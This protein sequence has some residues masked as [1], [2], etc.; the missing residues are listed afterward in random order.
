MSRSR[1]ATPSEIHAAAEPLSYTALLRDGTV[2]DVSL[3]AE[4]GNLAVPAGFANQR[5][6]TSPH[7]ARATVSTQSRPKL[8]SRRGDFLR[9]RVLLLTCDTAIAALGAATAIVVHR[10]H[11]VW[12]PG[13]WLVMMAVRASRDGRV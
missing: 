6:A 3:R 13:L 9:M 10:P 7:P 11:A 5:T 2:Q 1:A 8:R 12:I 4:T